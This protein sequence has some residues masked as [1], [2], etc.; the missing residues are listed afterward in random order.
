MPYV[1]A[2][3]RLNGGPSLGVIFGLTGLSWHLRYK[4]LTTGRTAQAF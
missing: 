2:S 1:T 4:D 3:M